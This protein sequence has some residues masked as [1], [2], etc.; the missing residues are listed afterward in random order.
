MR[1][2]DVE[3]C[4]FL[5]LCGPR[6]KKLLS[7]E[8]KMTFQD[9]QRLVYITGFLGLIHYNLKIWNQYSP[10]FGQKLK[11][12]E[13]IQEEESESFGTEEYEEEIIQQ[14]LWILELCDFVPDPEIRE[15]IRE[16]L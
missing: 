7:G 16:M 14:E 4:A 2:E 8:E 5:Y 9:F 10:Q 11:D 1:R 3:Q 15:R 12:M 13:R 6:D